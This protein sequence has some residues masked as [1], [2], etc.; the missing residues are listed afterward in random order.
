M[1]LRKLEKYL[2]TLYETPRSEIG[3]IGSCASRPAQHIRRGFLRRC[4]PFVLRSPR[5]HQECKHK[6]LSK[7]RRHF[8]YALPASLAIHWLSVRDDAALPPMSPV[9]TLKVTNETQLTNYQAKVTIL[10]RAA[11]L[12]LNLFAY[13]YPVAQTVNEIPYFRK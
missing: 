7:G 4:H 6:Q 10:Q 3:P 12:H 9:L 8:Q 11:Q 2:T 13:P 5:L 1:R